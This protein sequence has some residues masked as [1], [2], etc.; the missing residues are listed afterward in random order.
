VPGDIVDGVL[1]EGAGEVRSGFSAENLEELILTGALVNMK[2]LTQEQ[3]GTIVHEV[4]AGIIAQSRVDGIAKLK[5][6]MLWSFIVKNKLY[7]FAGDH[8][9]NAN[10]FLREVDIGM[11]RRSIERY[12]QVAHIFGDLVRE[13]PVPIRKLL[14]I[15][16]LCSDQDVAVIEEWFNKAKMLPSGALEDE[17]REATGR[18]TK[19]TCD[20][21]LDMQ[22]VWICCEKC[23]SFL[24]KIQ[25]APGGEDG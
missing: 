17:V 15:A 4:S 19:D 7:R 21:P 3:R 23:H 22:S 24:E 10:D 5:L 1:V 14:M 13:H 25:D 9:R 16:P 18:Q 20:H 2:S 8:I 12:A 11:T 6:G